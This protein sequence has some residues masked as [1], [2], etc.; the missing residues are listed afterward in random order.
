VAAAIVLLGLCDGY[1]Q[2]SPGI[3][4]V[5]PFPAGGAADLMVRILAD[6]ISRL[7]GVATVIENRPGA[8]S[9]IGT[10]AV[11]HAPPDGN[12]VLINANSFVISPSLRKL[13]YDPLISF[14]PICHL[15]STPMFIVVNDASPYRTLAGLLGAARE[16]PGMLTLGSLGPATAQHLAF[17]L[18][19][20][21]A[22]VD[23]SFVPFPGNVP[24]INALLGGHL[25]SSIA[26]YPDVIEH[27]RNRKLRA[28]ATTARTR[29]DGL[30]DVPTVAE[31]G[32]KDYGAEVW[33]GLVAPAKTHQNRIAQIASWFTTAMERPGIKSRL[34]VLGI[35]AKTMCGAEFGAYLRAQRET[36]ARIIRDANI[37]G[38]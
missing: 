23:V 29:I 22:N 14:E 26:N 20:R 10:E 11:A 9:V 16:K 38:Q 33:I 36:Y 19:K 34:A 5:I 12:T 28:L 4:I 3:K 30:P 1:T 24:A 6:E 27:I 25:T 2:T 32:F 35:F 8:G 7:H 31:Q 17:E 21:E 18:L 15:A 37:K 13:T